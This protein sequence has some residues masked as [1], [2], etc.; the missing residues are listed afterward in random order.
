MMARSSVREWREFG[1]TEGKNRDARGS[2]P[3]T[4]TQSTHGLGALLKAF[5]KTAKND[6]AS[7][8]SVF[9]IPVEAFRLLHCVSTSVVG[10][11]KPP[12]HRRTSSVTCAHYDS[13]G[14]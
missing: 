12:N 9:N 14:Q 3:P 11:G 8:S 1:I 5:T 7:R 10:E 4:L 2:S 13:F 6:Q